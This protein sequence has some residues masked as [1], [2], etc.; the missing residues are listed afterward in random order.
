MTARRVAWLLAAAL[1]V[2]AGAL[3]LAERRSAAPASGDGA[4]LLPGAREAVNAITEVRV[5]RGDAGRVTLRKGPKE[6]QVLERGYAA[7]SGK[8]RKLLLDLTGLQIVEEKTHDPANYARLGVEDVKGAQPGGVLVEVVAP[9]ATRAVIVGK[10]SGAK[11]SFVR[12]AGQPASFLAEPQ[13]SIEAD[14]RRWL[15]TSLLDVAAER[16]HRVEVAPA[17]GPAYSAVR[18]TPGTGELELRKLPKGRKPAG[19]GAAMPLASNLA[20]FDFEDVRAASASEAKPVGRAVVST[21]DGLVVELEGL[22]QGAH[23]YVQLAARFDPAL[24]Q[25]FAGKT[26]NAAGNPA[27][28]AA[29]DVEAEAAAI[30]ARAQGWQFE[31]PGWK[32]DSIFRPLEEMLQKR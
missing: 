31:I 19:A 17:A 30:N 4:M 6:W 22:E 11:A 25:R 13:L 26:E 28:R 20:D 10:P 3:W 21:F 8:V 5:T 14:P 23:R 12:L 16:V 32:F 7:D 1:L 27:L 2:I 9:E 15:A 24:A 18:D 29:A